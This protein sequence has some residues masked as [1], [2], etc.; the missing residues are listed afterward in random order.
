[1]ASGTWSE[2]PAEAV[3]K[4]RDNLRE[5]LVPLTPNTHTWDEHRGLLLLGHIRG[6]LDKNRQNHGRMKLFTDA[7]FG[8]IHNKSTTADN[9]SLQPPKLTNPS[10]EKSEIAADILHRNGLD[11]RDL[12]GDATKLS[13]PRIAKLPLALT[14]SSLF[15]ALLP[16]F[17]IS[18]LPQ[19]VLGRV[20]GDSTDEGIDARTSYQ[21]LAAMFGSIIIWP[22][23]ST[24]IVADVL[25]I[26]PNK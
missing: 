23:S 13:S 1:M 19:M 14:R 6:R 25:A 5:K 17:I 16:I 24:V 26:R 21:F 3:F 10:L 2:P 20:L 18:L 7:N 22:I 8:P 4:L 15:L 11:G 12:N 9:E